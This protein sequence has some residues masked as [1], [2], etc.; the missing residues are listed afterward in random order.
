MAL[1]ERAKG[2]II[3]LRNKILIHHERSLLKAQDFSI[4]SQNC[5]GGVFYHDMGMQFKSPTINLYFKCP[6]FVKFILNLDYY[7]SLEMKVTQGPEFPIGRLD[8]I[9]IYFQHYASCE[10]AKNK[11]EERK[12]RI[13]KEKIVVLCTD[14]DEFSEET[15]VEWEKIPY[16]KLLYSATYR[17]D[18][19]VLF[20]PEYN[21]SGRV[22]DLIPTREFY[23]NHY[24]IETINRA[25]S[26]NL[27]GY[28]EK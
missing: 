8:D 11:W 27:F 3:R 19:E 23:K 6:D 28:K 9:E 16:P 10:E 15:Y 20:Y 26:S 4:L 24:L 21:C 17:N 22:G 25:E 1:I 5:I 7:L 2:A 18:Q 14:R 12:R 13:N